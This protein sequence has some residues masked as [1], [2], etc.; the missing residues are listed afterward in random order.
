MLR[1]DQAV[2]VI[3]TET[4]SDAANFFS[5]NPP[6]VWFADGASLD[7]NEYTP[8]KADIPPYDAARIEVW[9]WTGVNIRKESQGDAREADSIQAAV[10]ARLRADDYVL[11]FDDDESGE[12]AD[13]VAVRV[14]GGIHAPIEVA[15]ELYHLKYSS[16]DTPGAR[17]GDLYVVCG[18]AQ[19]SIRWMSTHEKRTD[20]FT[21]LLRREAKRLSNGRPT[22][23]ERGDSRLVERLREMVHTTRMTLKIIV[24][25]PG[26]SK[27]SISDTQ[28]YLLS[29]TE[30]YLMET[31]QLGFSVVTS[32]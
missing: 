30:N 13:V 8:L 17:V 15:V 21:H 29:V 1:G 6:R 18:Q 14:V 12:A 7:G 26:V 20:L 32:E 25:Q 3:R 19:T 16:G 11:I 24:V 27:A 28:R 23:F 9:D 4:S 5:K 22:R 10:I 31:Y 2:D